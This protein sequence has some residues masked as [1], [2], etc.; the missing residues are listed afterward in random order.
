MSATRSALNENRLLR[1]GCGW[2]DC[3]GNCRSATACSA[4]APGQER[5]TAMV[6]CVPAIGCKRSLRPPRS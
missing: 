1:H 2:L 6:G 4:S 5:P 3:S